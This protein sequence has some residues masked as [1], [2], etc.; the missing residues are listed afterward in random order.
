M[1][2][3]LLEFKWRAVGRLLGMQADLRS[4]SNVFFREDLVMKIF[5]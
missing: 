3:A 1:V 5:L 2:G 4:T